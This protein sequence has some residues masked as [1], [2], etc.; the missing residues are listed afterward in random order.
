MHLRM[1]LLDGE[2]RGRSDKRWKG[3]D[4]GR[5]LAGN[6]DY[7]QGAA[8]AAGGMRNPNQPSFCP[9]P[10][11]RSSHGHKKAF[12][13]IECFDSRLACLWQMAAITL[14]GIVI[15]AVEGMDF[16]QQLRHK[17]RSWRRSR[18]VQTLFRVGAL[19]V[20]DSS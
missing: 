5:G 16:A 9:G 15:G 17:H 14:A 11:H 20:T 4:A 10:S 6:R 8:K 19:I 1:L 12:R 7:R 18:K 2:I 3:R 13:S